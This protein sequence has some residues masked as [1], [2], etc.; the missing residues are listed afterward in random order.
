MYISSIDISN[1]R[2]FKN[3]VIYFRNDINVIVG[4]NNAGKSNLIRALALVVDT[5]TSKTLS[6]SDFCKFISIEELESKAPKISITVTFKKGND[7]TPDDLV[8]LA[9]CLTKLEDDYE[10]QLTY[11][12]FLPEREQAQYL[13][14][15]KDITVTDS[16]EK[17]KIIW[18]KIDTNFLR[19]YKYKVWAGNKD[20]K[21]PVDGETIK[22]L[23]FQFLD[24]IRDVERDMLSGRNNLLKDVFQF[25]IDYDLKKDINSL[26]ESEI[27]SRLSKIKS[28]EE[29]FKGSSDKILQQ[30]HDRMN[31]GKCEIL[32][33]ANKT[34]A[35]FNDSSPDFDGEVSEK[36]MLFAL[37]LIIKKKSGITLPAT[38]NGLGY[39]NLIFMSLLLAKMQVNSNGS[40]MGSNAKIFPM[41]AIEEPEAHLHPSMQKKLLKFLNDKNNQARQV[42]ITTHSTH[43]TSSCKL[44]N[45]ISLHSENDSYTVS[46]P[47][48]A[49]GDNK[50]E[51]NRYVQRFLDATKSDMLFSQKIIFVEGIAEQLLIS[52]FAKYYD[53][54][55]KQTNPNISK[56]L[57]DNHISVINVGGRYF[58][59]FLKIF[60]TT[61][62]Y[63]IPK[64]VVC[65][66][67]RDPVRKKN[68]GSFEKCYPFETD[69]N[70][71]KYTYSD[72]ANNLINKYKDHNNIK[73]FSQNPKS[74]TFEY[75]LILS[76]P[77]LKLL[78]TDS[79]SN[80]DELNSL[81]ESIDEL[82]L[83]DFIKLLKTG[84]EKNPHKE[85]D[86]IRS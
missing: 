22:K 65:L 18:K 11:E 41:L 83:D 63:A 5:S 55:V 42:F 58:E 53:N 44:D 6:V 59:H 69:E 45:I 47:T 85:N 57:E 39:N 4:H 24:A 75:E 3:Q 52:T 26:D 67:D 48:K 49:L 34:G 61:N 51:S 20:N 8:T 60:D 77:T 73:Y 43:I 29:M 27:D 66:T 12:F 81:M 2:S 33:Y 23:D 21:E 79:I 38:H 86:R 17:K 13:N 35:D 50:S 76:N 64:N 80:R 56:N 68:S 10:A 9:S 54:E 19:K 84:S 31:E 40:Y 25:F 7:H 16:D 37:Q 78:L 72:N 71:A 32:G 14:E 74:K 28:R 46:Y 15:L 70:K 62:K 82:K 1:Y 30:L 36:D